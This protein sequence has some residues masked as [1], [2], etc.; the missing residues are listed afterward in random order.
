MV[1]VA[2]GVILAADV[3][4]APRHGVLLRGHRARAAAR[5]AAAS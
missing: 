2:T 5:M 4:F 1:A 3:L